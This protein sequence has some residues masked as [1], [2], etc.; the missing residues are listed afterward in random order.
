M[1]SAVQA[2]NM[3]LDKTLLLILHVIT[4]EIEYNIYYFHI[5]AVVK[6]VCLWKSHNLDKSVLDTYMRVTVLKRE[7]AN[8]L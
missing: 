2:L 6:M 3:S 4:K 7:Y 1:L 8:V 5:Y